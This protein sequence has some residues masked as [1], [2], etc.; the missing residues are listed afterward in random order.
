MLEW[1]SE[2]HG[3]VVAN[4]FTRQMIEEAVLTSRVQ[5]RGALKSLHD[6]F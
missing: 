2:S 3:Y 4:R 1:W 5:L 6:C